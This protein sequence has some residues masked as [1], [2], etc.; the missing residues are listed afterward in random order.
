MVLGPCVFCLWVSERGVEET[1]S[2][3]EQENQE[4]ILKQNK[5]INESSLS[6]IDLEKE[7]MRQVRF[8]YVWLITLGLLITGVCVLVHGTEAR[9]VI[10]SDW[11]MTID[12]Y[13]EGG[14]TYCIMGEKMDASDGVDQYDI[15]HPP[16]QP[17]GR[18]FVFIK[19]PSFPVPHNKLW[20]EYRHLHG[21]WR[22]WNLTLFYV[23]M[24]EE[25]TNVSL[26]WD[27]GQVL[28]SGYRNV[29]LW[30]NGYA[31]DMKTEN[32]YIFYSLPYQ[33][34]SMKIYCNDLFTS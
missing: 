10:M 24:D 7:R 15:P 20:M 12:V 32:S 30:N 13:A 26:Q 34:T 1:M 27:T 19:Q 25:G 28:F 33:T 2:Y 18:A 4:A 8:F 6:V 21:L 22:V 5:I 17:P 31:A 3:R 16:F 11:Q 23:P 29:I 14:H 9:A